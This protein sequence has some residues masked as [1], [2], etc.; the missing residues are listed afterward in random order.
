[1]PQQLAM[2]NAKMAGD[3]ERNWLQQMFA[4]APGFM[5]ILEGSDHRFTFANRAFEE[6][7]ERSDI[8]GKSLIEAVPEIVEQAL[9][10]WWT[11]PKV[12]ASHSL[13]EQ[14]R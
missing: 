5:A 12:R 14:C 2:T 10:I 3:V 8:V 9:S 13:A 11:K 1:M 4:E 6:L 7:V